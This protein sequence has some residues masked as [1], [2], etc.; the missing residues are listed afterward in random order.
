MDIR[1]LYKFTLVDFPA[2]LGCVL[3]VGGCNF[4]CPFCHNPCLVFD[5]ASQPRI[6]ETA[7]FNFLNRRVGKLDGVVISG[8]EPTLQPGLGAFAVKG[9]QLGF[10]IKID[11]NGSLPAVIE[12]LHQEG[13]LDALG[14]DFKAPS[15]RYAA[16]TGSALPDCAERVKQVIRFAL[17]Q[18]IQLDVRTTV[19]RDL[20]SPEDLNAMRRELD[21]LGVAD[22]TL[23]QFNPVEVIDET[24]P[25]RPTYSDSEL[26]HLAR[27]LGRTQVRGL[28]GLILK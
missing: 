28:N 10:D 3:F 14:V 23:Q 21:A 25:Q 27:A 13:G 6:T 19:H 8:G 9:K 12:Q 11:T 22:W 2:H 16:L 24:L 5:P 26:V 20:L 17:E 4:R 18:G 15:G 1:G 7:V